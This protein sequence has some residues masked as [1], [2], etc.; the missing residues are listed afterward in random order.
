M[1]KRRTGGIQRRTRASQEAMGR[2]LETPRSRLPWPIIALVGLVALAVVAVLV[3]L[4][5]G[6]RPNPNAGTAQPDDGRAHIPNCSPG[7]YSSVPATSGCHDGS[8]GA[9]GVYAAPAQETQMIHNLEHGG[10]V[11]WYQPDLLEAEQI[12]QL[13][14]YVNTQVQSNRFK[15]ILA[16]W[17]GEDFGHP[18][19]LN[20]WQWQL[21]QDTVDLGVIRD[22]VSI[23]YGDAP[24]PNGGPGPPAV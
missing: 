16:P 18:I 9:W 20:A 8:P 15:V 19:A 13:E 21:Y 7:A 17:A 6:S 10:I 14:G 2:R 23:H 4:V 3:A 11:I 24:E 5:A 22:F 12:E 1:A